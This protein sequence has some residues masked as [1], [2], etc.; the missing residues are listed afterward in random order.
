MD[1]YDSNDLK[2]R[3]QFLKLAGATTV[4]AAMVA[5]G[6]VP[7]A[8]PQPA[9][10][11][12][13]EPVELRLSH[14][15]G[16]ALKDWMY[17][18]EEKHNAKITIESASWGEYFDK[19]LTQLVGG[20]A[21]DVIVMSPVKGAHFFLRG[22]FLPLDDTL[23]RRAIDNSKWA[24]P[25]DHL[26]WQG[27]ILN[28]PFVPHQ[29]LGAAV[30]LDLIEKMGFEVPHPWPFWGTPEFDRFSYEHY[31]E[32][33]M[34][35]TKMTDSGETEVYGSTETYR[36][37]ITQMQIGTY[38][39]GGKIF[40][41]PDN[42]TATEIFVNSSEVV[43]VVQRY[44]DQVLEH[45]VSPM[46]GA[47]EGIEGGLFRAQKAAVAPSW[48][49][50][51]SWGGAPDVVGFNW[52]PIM[53]PNFR[54]GNRAVTKM[55]DGLS[56]NKGSPH[57]D[58]AADVIVTMITDWDYMSIQAEAFASP[59]AYNTVAYMPLY[60]KEPF[61]KETVQCWLSRYEAFSECSYC[62]ENLQFVAAHLGRQGP[63]VGDTLNAEIQAVI[64]GQ[65][66]VQQAMDDAKV[67]IDVE[68]QR[69]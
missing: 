3:R 19:T 52:R 67:A 48:V 69:A 21:P 35:C 29:I 8:A 45:R 49:A 12:V 22:V 56:A 10:E 50:P 26:K 44:V 54:T 39:N 42:F 30:N 18:L 36:G 46:P 28:I 23:A 7:T 63:F 1:A 68:L 41:D 13:E 9:A 64:A 61:K 58:V 14:W 32:N 27:S 34:A 62:T 17:I 25:I 5:A 38:E 37:W 33:L 24:I 20:V 66:T 60:E 40:D 47:A 2:S 4:S 6:C 51:G 55:A 65:K 15:W 53:F 11:I 59:P 16:D 57:A 43:E 31:L